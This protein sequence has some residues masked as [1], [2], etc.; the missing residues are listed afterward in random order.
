MIPSRV[1]E[2]AHPRR[3]RRKR[4]KKEKKEKREMEGNTWIQSETYF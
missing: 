3:K 2:A 1:H 4:W